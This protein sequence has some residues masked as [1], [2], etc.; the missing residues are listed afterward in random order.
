[1][2]AWGGGAALASDNANLQGYTDGANPDAD[3]DAIGQAAKQKEVVDANSRNK[4]VA[5]AKA[6]NIKRHSR[7]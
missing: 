3:M 1:V 5:V 7:S 2:L 6:L 4:K